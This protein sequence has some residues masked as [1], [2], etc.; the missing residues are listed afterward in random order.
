ME[1]SYDFARRLVYRSKIAPFTAI[2]NEA[3]PS[4]ISF[5]RFAAMLYGDDVVWLMRQERIVFM[6]KAIFT[7]M[8]GA[9]TNHP[10][11]FDR[12]IFAHPFLASLPHTYPGLHHAHQKFGLLELLQFVLKI[13]I[14]LASAVQRQKLRSSLGDVGRWPKVQ[15]LFIGRA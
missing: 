13:V 4:Q 11:K 8:T 14:H 2:A 3:G 7:S 1:E 12:N 9:F 15:D 10:T 6:K 5:G